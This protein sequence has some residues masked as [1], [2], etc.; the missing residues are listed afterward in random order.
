M[1]GIRNFV[2]KDGHII[3]LTLSFQLLKISIFFL[4]VYF[5][6]SG[7]AVQQR[8]SLFQGLE[9]SILADVQD[10][11]HQ[12]N[13]YISELRCAYE[14]ARNCYDSHVM[15]II[16]NARAS[17]EHER[18]YNVPTSKDI[19]VL[20]LKDPVGYREAM[21]EDA[22]VNYTKLM[23]LFNIPSYFRLAEMAGAFS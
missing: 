22:S 11:L 16:E 2:F 18:R 3:E 9:L 7:E 20:M 12:H 13:R 6:D 5:M 21:S 14:F 17:A 4:Q 15:V 8:K 10:M 23:T 19:A 1:D